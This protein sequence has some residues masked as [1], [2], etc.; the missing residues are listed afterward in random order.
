LRPTGTK[1]G[2]QTGANEGG[3]RTG[4]IKVRVA[5]RLTVL[6][7]IE[8][9]RKDRSSGKRNNRKAEIGPKKHPSWGR[10]ENGKILLEGLSGRGKEMGTDWRASEKQTEPLL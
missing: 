8:E 10:P 6:C 5:N 7:K 9:K 3:R 1:K 2:S 4:K